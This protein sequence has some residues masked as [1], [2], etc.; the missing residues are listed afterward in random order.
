MPFVTAHLSDSRTLLTYLKRV[1][2]LRAMQTVI[3]VFINEFEGKDYKMLLNDLYDSVTE[4]EGALIFKPKSGK[5]FQFLSVLREHK[6]QYGTH[7]NSSE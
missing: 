5:L 2:I 1:Y 7:F 6:I 3:T 4:F